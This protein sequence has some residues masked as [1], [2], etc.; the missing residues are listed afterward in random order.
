MTGTV[1]EA[2]LTCVSICPETHR[3]FS[4]VLMRSLQVSFTRS[5]Q[6]THHA[7]PPPVEGFLLC[8]GAVTLR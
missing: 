6:V 8:P 5:V 7:L 1:W 4:E 2:H 3:Q